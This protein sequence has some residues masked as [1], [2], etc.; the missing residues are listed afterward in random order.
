MLQASL[1]LHL[2][3]VAQEASVRLPALVVLASLLHATL[4]AQQQPTVSPAV[5]AGL[6]VTPKWGQSKEVQQDYEQECY[7]RA[8]VQT[9]ADPAW[10]AAADSAAAAQSDS[11][12]GATAGVIYGRRSARAE[13]LQAGAL[14]NFRKAMTACLEGGG[15][16][17]K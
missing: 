6:S 5:Q 8:R 16:D 12:S 15:Y 10:V 14:E 2:E 13:R 3:M 11:A 7:D 4:A 17:V 9:G 1:H